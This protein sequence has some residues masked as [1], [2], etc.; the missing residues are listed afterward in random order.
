LPAAVL[1][2]CSRMNTE[3]PGIEKKHTEKHRI[4]PMLEKIL[5]ETN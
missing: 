3:K 4:H 2:I 5:K 1:N